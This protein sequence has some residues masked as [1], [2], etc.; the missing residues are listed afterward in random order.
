[1]ET[2]GVTADGYPVWG[3]QAELVR[4]ID[5]SADPTIPGRYV[6]PAH[7][8][9]GRNVV[10]GGQLLAQAI[11]AASK[12]VPAQRVTSAHMVFAKAASFDVDVDVDVDVLRRGRTF[13]TA[14]VR[15]SQSGQLRA[16]GM[17]LLDSGAADVIRSAAAM[18][19]VPGPD[20]AVPLD[21][22]VSGRQLRVVDAAYTAAPEATG[23]AEIFVWTRFRD[24]PPTQH[25]HA[26]LVA[27][28][29]THWTIAAA[30]RPH[31]GYGEDAAHVTL[32]TGILATTIALFDD[33]DVSDWLL[34][35]N[36]AIYAGRG[37]V[38]GE[39]RVFTADGRLVAS[40]S[41]QAM[42]RGF[43]HDPSTM[44]LDRSNAM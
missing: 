37:L 39:G 29:T 26:A 13:S 30:M 1:V 20:D 15:T 6:G 8:T 40:Y 22:G 41:V 3:D 18:P 43:G 12:A 24:A 23:P 31:P 11:V 25:L 10:E 33:I 16:A 36:T 42:I 21:M 9:T 34:S 35:T 5:V 7:P 4:L 44:G 27:Q 38:Q 2:P 14:E 32:S 28:S 17:V 19:D